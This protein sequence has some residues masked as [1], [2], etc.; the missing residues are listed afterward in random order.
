MPL[1]WPKTIGTGDD[2]SIAV[3]QPP[4]FSGPCDGYVSAMRVVVV[5]SSDIDRRDL[6]EHIAADDELHVV[7]PAVAQSRLQWLANDEDDARAEA[8]AVAESVGEAA[9]VDPAT[10]DVKP[11]FPRQL[12]LDAIA[13]HRPD[14]VIVALRD[15]EEGTWLEDGELEELPDE[16]DGIP[17][18]RIRL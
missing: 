18:V 11:D 13:E 5:T 9:P 17:L 3:R 10:I 16:V 14:R 15:R 1:T 6:A 2:P 12:V 7:V 4:G 8:V